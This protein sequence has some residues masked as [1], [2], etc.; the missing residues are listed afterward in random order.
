MPDF[1]NLV[2]EPGRT[3]AQTLGEGSGGVEKQI[4]TPEVWGGQQTMRFRQS[5]N[6]AGDRGRDLM[7][8]LGCRQAPAA[9]IG[10]AGDQ[11]V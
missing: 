6:V 11:P 3:I 5:D 2:Q 1:D 8:E 10:A 9:G 7:L 4:M